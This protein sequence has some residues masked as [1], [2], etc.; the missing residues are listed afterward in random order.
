MVLNLD[1][2]TEGL[3]FNCPKRMSKI[4]KSDYQ[5]SD[6]RILTIVTNKKLGD[7]PPSI[8]KQKYSGS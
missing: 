7:G 5:S 4:L 1:W 8:Y 3:V 6:C 2:F